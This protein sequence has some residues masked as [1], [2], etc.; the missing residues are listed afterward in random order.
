M[1]TLARLESEGA[2]ASSIEAAEQRAVL[3]SWFWDILS[4]PCCRPQTSMHSTSNAATPTHPPTQTPTPLP[5]RENNTGGFPHRLD[6]FLHMLDHRGTYLCPPTP[7]PPHPSLH[8]KNTDGFPHGPNWLLPVLLFMLTRCAPCPA[9]PGPTP[10]TGREN[11]TGGFP[12]GLNQFL[13]ALQ[14]WLYGKDPLAPLQWLG[15]LDAIKFQ[16]AAHEDVF[17]EI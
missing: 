9:I 4:A 17:G 7:T 14:F 1:S 3:P 6:Q 13:R 12:R 16:L 8:R 15:P 2:N 5:G 11:N 10:T